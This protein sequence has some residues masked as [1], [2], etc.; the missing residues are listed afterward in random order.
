VFVDQLEQLFAH[1]RELVNRLEARTLDIHNTGCDLYSR[2]D[3]QQKVALSPLLR[4]RQLDDDAIDYVP[5]LAEYRQ[6]RSQLVILR[7]AAGHEVAI[8]QV[9]SSADAAHAAEDG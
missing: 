9:D 3:L 4:Q 7:P 6:Q 1:A 2:I 5:D 8:A